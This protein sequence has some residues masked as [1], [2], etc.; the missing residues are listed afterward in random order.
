MNSSNI[1]PNEPFDA[2]KEKDEYKEYK[3]QE[4][5][6]KYKKQVPLDYKNTNNRSKSTIYVNK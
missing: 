5:Y 2:E 6:A 1:K 4:N 3:L